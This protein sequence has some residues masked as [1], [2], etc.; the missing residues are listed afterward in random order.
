MKT[1]NDLPDGVS[2]VD[3]SQMFESDKYIQPYYFF[4]MHTNKIPNV[5]NYFKVNT[6]SLLEQLRTFYNLPT[7]KMFI[8]DRFL[9]NKKSYFTFRAMLILKPELMIFLEGTGSEGEA[10]ILYSDVINSNDLE[11]I[12]QAIKDEIIPQET[13]QKLGILYIDSKYELSIKKVNLNKSELNIKLLYND[14][15]FPIHEV[16]IDKLT[17]SNNGIILLHG[18]PG[19]GKTSYIR[20]LTSVIGKNMIYIPPDFAHH[21]SSPEFISLM[22]ENPDS[23]L[24][25]EDAENVIKDRMNSDGLSVANLLSISDGLLSDCLNIQVICTFNTDISRIDKALLRKGRIIAKY[26][27]GKLSIDK[28]KQLALTLGFDVE[29]TCPMTLAEIFYL[30]DYSF[31]NQQETKIG[32]LN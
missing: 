24:I 28:T 12:N 27:F 14:D 10:E 20:Y 15:F 6:D 1:R 16:I 32:F 5:V 21:L 31:N 7:D 18:T 17:N 4:Y 26:E 25:I 2:R 3:Y 22:L 8:Y 30:K 23:I 9:P 19:T 29:I 11:A 13:I